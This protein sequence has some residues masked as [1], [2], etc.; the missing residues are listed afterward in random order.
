MRKQVRGTEEST[1]T[2]SSVADIQK[3]SR[4]AVGGKN[5]MA[6]QS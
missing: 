4:A 6:K 5:K 1:M 3:V 2:M